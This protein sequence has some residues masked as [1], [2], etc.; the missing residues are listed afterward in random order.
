MFGK[1]ILSN[2]FLVTIIACYS[3]I[4]P[5]TEVGVIINDSTATLLTPDGTKTENVEDKSIILN[6]WQKE[7]IKGQPKSI[8]QE[9]FEFL[10]NDVIGMRTGEN[11]ETREYN[12]TGFVEK[13][14]IYDDENKLTNSAETIFLQLNKKKKKI[15]YDNNNSI[16]ME[17]SYY[18]DN[19]GQNDSCVYE[20]IGKG[21]TSQKSVY[22]KLGHEIE[23]KMYGFSGELTQ[24]GFTTYFNNEKIQLKLEDANGIPYSICKYQNNQYGDPIKEY[25]YLGNNVLFEEYKNEYTYDSLNNW[26]VK[27]TYLEKIHTRTSDNEERIEGPYRITMRTFKYN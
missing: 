22:D 10:Q 6:D 13:L 2:L 15:F 16:I 14:Y 5:N 25:Y 12:S 26:V 24:T 21:T 11:T 4:P 7:N 17:F 20:F 18:Y 19:T 9:E 23:S 8:R 1:T 3:C 27:K